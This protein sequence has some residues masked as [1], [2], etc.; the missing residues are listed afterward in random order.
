MTSKRNPRAGVTL[1]ELLIAVSLVSLLSTA[2]LVALHVGLNAMEKTNSRVIRNR[3]VLGAQRILE[4]Q[5][6]G[7]IVTV[8]ACGI[9]AGG[10]V[11]EL[12]FFE[13]R[14]QTMRFVSSYSLEEG[15]RGYPRI[16]EYQVIPR[17]DGRGVRLIVNE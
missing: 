2:V 6:A 8:A 17:D 13:G 11:A 9:Q 10:P 16:L 3:R 15:H 5:I 4:Q 1:L 7:M 12:P 14:P